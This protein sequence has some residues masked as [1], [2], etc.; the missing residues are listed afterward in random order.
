MPSS[1][2]V[3]PAPSGSRERR[4]V[5]RRRMHEDLVDILV[6]D[7]CDGAYAIGGSLPSERSLMEEFGVSRLTVREAMAALEV[8]GFIEVR[9]GTRAR[10]CGPRPGFLLELLSQAATFHLHRP[11]GLRTFIEVRELVEAGVVRMATERACDAQVEDLAAKLEENRSAIGNPTRFAQTDIDFHFAIARI[12]ENPIVDSFFHASG[13]WLHQV[14][15]TCLKIEGQM[16]TAYA[17]HAKI[18]EC[19]A[20]REPDRAMREMRRHLLQ[21]ASIYSAMTDAGGL[22]VGVST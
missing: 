20:A 13:H 9:P 14:R 12:V 3:S 1:G 19:V 6:T 5:R 11:D 8:R 17:A 16:D 18:F 22:N 21:V 15:D 4:T 10:V 7:I 2:I